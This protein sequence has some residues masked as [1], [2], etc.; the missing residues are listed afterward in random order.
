TSPESSPRAIRP[1]N[2]SASPKNIGRRAGGARNGVGGGHPPGNESRHGVRGFLRLVR[3]VMPSHSSAG[4]HSGNS[5]AATTTTTATA[6]TATTMSASGRGGEGRRQR[7]DPWLAVG[8]EGEEVD[9][10]VEEE[11]SARYRRRVDHGGGERG[12]WPRGGG[13][14]DR[15]REG[16]RGDALLPV[17][18]AGGGEA[19][20]RGGARGMAGAAGWGGG[21]ASS[22]GGSLASPR[23]SLR[24]SGTATRLRRVEL[25]TPAEEEEAAV[26]EAR[27]V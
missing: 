19:G 12:E 11:E 9:G 20:R 16:G 21:L 25:R 2:A 7:R 10:K 24:S 13:D 23:S 1:R 5:S 22:G 6:T 4:P 15:Y 14:A 18:R 27:E 3:R 17:R 26:R 8:G